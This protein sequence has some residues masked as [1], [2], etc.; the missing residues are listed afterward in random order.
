M[1]KINYYYLTGETDAKTRIEYTN[2]FNANE[3]V[4]VFLIS[5]K[6]G[7]TGLNLIGA[8]T[9]IHLDPW[10]NQAVE[11]QAT[12]RTYRIGQDKNVMVHRMI[13]LGTFEEKIDEMLK[14]KKELAD[15][16]VYEGEKIITELTDEEIYEIFS[17]TA[18]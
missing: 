4:K 2:E 8:D 3:D 5:L 9:V 12:D 7:G 15:L 1:R 14:S 6:A 10:W 11:D 16:A 17:L 18:G 13:T